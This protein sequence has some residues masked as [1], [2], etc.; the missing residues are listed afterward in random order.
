[1]DCPGKIVR[2]GFLDLRKEFDLIEHNKLLENFS[3]IGARRL[4]AQ[5]WSYVWDL[6][7]MQ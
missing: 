6:T 4:S 2:I 5:L 1:M 7:Y 3:N